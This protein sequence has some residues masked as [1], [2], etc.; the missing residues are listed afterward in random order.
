MKILFIDSYC[1]RKNKIGFELMCKANS[2]EYVI[3]YDPTHFGDAY[4]LVIVPS[5][6]INPQYFHNAKRI[7]YGPHNF[8]FSQGIWQGPQQIFPP[9]CFYDILS[10]WVD[11]LQKEFGGLSLASRAVPFA[12]DVDRFAPS[13]K[14]MKYDCFLYFKG[15]KHELLPYAEGRLKALGLKYRVI[16]YGSYKEDEYIDVLQTSR[17]GVW[18][19]RHESQGFALQEAL[20]TNVPLAVWDVKSM[21]EEYDSK[22]EKSYKEDPKVYKLTGT[23]VPYWDSSCGEVFTEQSEFDAT[24]MKVCQNVEKYNPREYILKTLSPKACYK[25][26]LE[27][28]ET[29]P[30]AKH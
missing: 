19:G 1:H 9:H 8:V 2:V 17:F 16:Q 22:N 15:R 24:V 23:C 26:L 18:V 5:E 20:S 12:V 25:H 3:S 4:D 6:A 13:L 27:V 7:M 21:F 14:P 10:P 28:L 30:E 29:I 11:T